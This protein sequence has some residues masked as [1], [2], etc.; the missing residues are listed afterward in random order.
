MSGFWWW[1]AL[2]S[3]KDGAANDDVRGW[4]IFGLMVFLAIVVYVAY[5]WPVRGSKGK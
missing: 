1:A 4:I 3:I 5:K 2:E